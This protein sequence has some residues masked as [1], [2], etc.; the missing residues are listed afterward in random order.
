[1]ENKTLT[2][3]EIDRSKIMEEIEKLHKLFHTMHLV[4][5]F[6]DMYPSLGFNGEQDVE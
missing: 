6:I 5:K 1:M 2:Q 3:E 4:D